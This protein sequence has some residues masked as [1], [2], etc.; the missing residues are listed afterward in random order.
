MLCRTESLALLAGLQ[1]VGRFVH[2]VPL[3]SGRLPQSLL[4][5]FSSPRVE[6]TWAKK[7]SSDVWGG[8]KRGG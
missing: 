6:A 8:F 7:C 5:L 3:P 1:A 4:A 2:G